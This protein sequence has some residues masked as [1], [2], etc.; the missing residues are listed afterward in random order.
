MIEALV[1]GGESVVHGQ[2][3][4]L[5]TGQTEQLL[6]S[7]WARSKA[8]DEGDW[9]S[10]RAFPLQH[11]RWESGVGGRPDQLNPG[12]GYYGQIGLE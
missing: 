5:W 12:K 4:L 3:A 7:H 2:E 9:L 1:I 8:L 10:S 6:H 11:H